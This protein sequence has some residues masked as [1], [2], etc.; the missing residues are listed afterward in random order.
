MCAG[1]GQDRPISIEIKKF[2]EALA[3]VFRPD[4]AHE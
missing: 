1:N 2:S 4:A 3:P